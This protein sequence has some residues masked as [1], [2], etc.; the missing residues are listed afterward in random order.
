MASQLPRWLVSC[1]LAR[2]LLLRGRRLCGMAGLAIAS[3]LMPIQIAAQAPI[4]FL[5]YS[6]DIEYGIIANENGICR[7]NDRGSLI[8]LSGQS[9]LGSGTRGI[10][11][12]MGEP[13]RVIYG[14]NNGAGITFTPKI[15]GSATKVLGANGSTILV[16]AGDLALENASSG[17]HSLDYLV[18]VHYE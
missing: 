12:I 16:I 1:S 7:M 14:S 4:S 8:G 9:C 10:F 13:G 17:K 6:S 2:L 18:C 11:N 3:Q 15:S 5:P